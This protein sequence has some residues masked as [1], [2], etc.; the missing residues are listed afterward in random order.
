MAYRE[1]VDEQ[2]VQWQAWEVVP[3][4][5][6]R[7]NSGERRFGVRNQRDRRR[8][9]EP[10][11]RMTD[12]LAD[13]WLVFESPREKRRLRPIPEDWAQRTDHELERLCDTAESAPRTTPRLI[14]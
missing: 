4:S 5:A 7:R 14:E 2:G 8:R 10:R 6:E 11:I 13:G 12:G 9:S 3:T 1:F